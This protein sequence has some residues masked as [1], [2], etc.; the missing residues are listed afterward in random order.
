M[1]IQFAVENFLSF[2]GKTVL[3][4]RPAPTVAR[5][6]AA[7]D[8][9]GDTLRCA[10][11]YGANA[12]GKS[13][14]VTAIAFAKHFICE[15]VAEKA[16]IETHRFRLAA[17]AKDAP[18]SF[19]LYLR[20]SSGRAYG[21]G[22]AVTRDRILRE[23]LS[24][25]LGAHEELLFERD[26]KNF[27]F[28]DALF[29]EPRGSETRQ[30]LTAIHPGVRDNQLLLR[31][32]RELKLERFP[33]PIQ[34][35]VEWFTDSLVIVSPDTPFHALP[36]GIDRSAAFREF[37]DTLLA[38][39]DTGIS[40]IRA[41]RREL[42]PGEQP[43]GFEIVAGDGVYF[44]LEGKRRTTYVVPA[45]GP[46]YRI[47]LRLDHRGN[48]DD[49]VDFSLEDESDGTVR[50]LDLAH[51][52][53]PNTYTFQ[54]VYIVDELDRSMHTLLSRW[55]LEQ[56]LASSSSPTRQLVFTTHDTNLLDLHS[57]RPDS[58]WFTEK[59]RDGASSL[60]SLAEYKQEQLDALCGHLEEGYLLGRFGAIP[61]L[62]DP[63]RLGWP[64]PKDPT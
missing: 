51:I 15:G 12:S 47:D 63:T 44:D 25:V 10:A 53:Y 19:E 57:L 42:R 48:S 22:F 20:A 13:N 7:T 2:H 24:E 6:A 3:S 64:P 16:K 17:S 35:V 39:A 5:D 36:L 60:H 8:I 61:F 54:T 29:V 26:G 62:G 56:F 9:A 34:D 38:Q 55:F 43:S 58:V 46:T 49:A 28:A 1:L 14:L 4:M 33:R 18:S 37:V 11:V 59:G 30:L 50:L 23:W 45:D 41:R 31:T 27:T 52:L 32:A 40:A 21:Y